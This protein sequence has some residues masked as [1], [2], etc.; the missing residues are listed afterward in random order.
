[1]SVNDVKTILAEVLD[2]D[3][4]TISGDSYL[5]EDLGVESIDFLEIAVELNQKFGINVIDDVIFF[6]SLKEYLYAEDR[7][8]LISEYSYLDSKRVEEILESDVEE[9]LL[10]VSDIVAYIDRYEY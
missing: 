3:V 2:I 8:S 7:D 1:M 9:P 5:I 6:R 4:S 10:K